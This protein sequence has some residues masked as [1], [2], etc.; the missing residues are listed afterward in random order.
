MQNLKTP[1]D[2]RVFYHSNLDLSQWSQR[3]QER[4]KE[5]EQFLKPKDSDIQF[6]CKLSK[7][8]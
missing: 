8:W 4:Y 2:K 7:Q 1:W 3:T 5:A 6:F